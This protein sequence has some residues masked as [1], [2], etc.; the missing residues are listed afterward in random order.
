MAA[1][2]AMILTTISTNISNL[3]HRI[4]NINNE[5]DS[6]GDVKHYFH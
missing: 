6:S 1:D 5:G 2:K 4:E 3:L